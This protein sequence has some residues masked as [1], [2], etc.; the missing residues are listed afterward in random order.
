MKF[1]RLEKKLYKYSIK[2]LP[3]IVI[4][5]FIMGYFLYFAM[6][7][8]YVKLVLN[9]FLMVEQNEYWRL[10]TWIFTVPFDPDTAL[11][12]ILIPIT[13]FFYYFVAKRLEAAWG[14]VMFNL[15]MIGG[16]ILIDGAVLLTAFI[17]FKWSTGDL[18]SYYSDILMSSAYGMNITYFTTMSMFLAFAAIYSEQVI[19]LYFMI[20]IKVKWLGYFDLGYLIY[21]FIKADNAFARVIIISSVANFFIYFFINKRRGVRENIENYKRRK[22]FQR[23]VR[24]ANISGVYKGNGQPHQQGASSQGNIQSEAKR[25]NPFNNNPPTSGVHRCVICGR[26]DADNEN[27]E[28]R[29]CSKCNG[30]LEYCM[31]H[32]YTH[33]HRK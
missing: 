7:D 11:G 18:W 29:Y 3:E 31:D 15:Y 9:P 2:F 13:C 6:P 12:I 5:C 28:F 32:L 23:R 27:L 14:M 19:M 1:A 16:F 25:I 24:G 10:V 33:E 20:P 22:D 4:G 30:G 17:K 8:I 21:E 26:T